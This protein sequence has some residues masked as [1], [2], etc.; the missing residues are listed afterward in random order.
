MS[1]IKRKLA[2]VEVIDAAT[3]IPDADNIQSYSVGG[4]N[5]VAK[6]SEFSIGDKVIFFEIDAFV[7]HE[8]APFLTKDKPKNY[9]GIEGNRIKTIKLRGVLSQGLIL[10]ITD[11]YKDCEVGFD[12]TEALGV[13]KYEVIDDSNN[14]HQAA[15]KSSF[16]S[17][18]QK[19]DQERIQ[20]CYKN[21][22][23][24][25]ERNPDKDLWQV[26]EKLE[27]SSVTVA[28]FNGEV[29]LCSR[30]M[31]IDE[32]DPSSNYTLGAKELLNLAENEIIE[33]YA[34]QG[35]LIG[36]RIQGNIYQLNSVS[37]RV[38][39]VF[40]IKTGRYL[41]PDEREEFI[42]NIAMETNNLISQAPILERVSL[43]GLSLQD[44]LEMADGNSQ[45]ADTAREGIVFKN[46]YENITFKAI[47]NKY[48][49]KGK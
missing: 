22:M 13:I 21:I 41:T 42:D 1:E 10:P 3:A 44:I 16:P 9:N 38:F 45:L 39:D 25:I 19:T 47:S 29:Y 28:R 43:S 32:N 20:N 36:N 24:F 40:N 23:N 12:L 11:E 2:R 4:W 30:N 6:K 8:I 27:G 14:S 26:E 15:I 31:Q 46:C 37:V 5:V 17:F 49:L 33:G 7:P 34:L 18:I 35:E 48:L